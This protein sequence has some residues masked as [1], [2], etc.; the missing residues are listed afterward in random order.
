MSFPGFDRFNA[1]NSVQRSSA[2]LS[3]IPLA[4]LS[5]LPPHLLA[6]TITRQEHREPVLRKM[7]QLQ[8]QLTGKDFESWG[9]EKVIYDPEALKLRWGQPLS[10]TSAVW[11]LA[12]EPFPTTQVLGTGTITSKGSVWGYFNVNL[13]GLIPNQPPANGA[14]DYYIKVYPQGDGLAPTVMVKILYRRDAS[15]TDFTEQGI[16]PAG[17]R[18]VD[19]DFTQSGETWAQ[20]DH[21][22]GGKNKKDWLCFLSRIKGTFSGHEEKVRVYADRNG[23]WL[24]RTRSSEP[25][26]AAR[27]TCVH[28]S[29]L[30]PAPGGDPRIDDFTLRWSDDDA[31]LCGQP[32]KELWPGTSDKI[33]FLNGMMGPFV[34]S[35]ESIGLFGGTLA[36]DQ[37]EDGEYG[38]YAACA[39]T[40]FV[41]NDFHEIDTA[42]GPFSRD[43]LQVG[44]GLCALSSIRGE[45]AAGAMV[46]IVRS[47]GWWKLVATGHEQNEHALKVRSECW[48]WNPRDAR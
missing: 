35:K 1:R 10:S 2:W 31:L 29:L 6:G 3:L 32:K 23:N 43:L 33:C 41:Q 17:A 12:S 8:V 46:E 5:M 36:L 27:A 48:V 26:M 45:F 7:P 37:C 4:M 28:A 15:R 40:R 13:A 30:G 22:L 14:E 20:A 21:A 47:A 18:I 11:K 16:Y 42:K 38:A 25:G 9:A 34:S 44:K 24:L 39:T 19:F